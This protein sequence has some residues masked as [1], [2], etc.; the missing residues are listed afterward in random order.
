MSPDL[1]S[2]DLFT[3]AIP[4]MMTAGFVI[5]VVIMVLMAGQNVIYFIQL[6]IAY[7]VLSNR[8]VVPNTLQ[9]WR[10]L[11]VTTMPISLL[12]PAYNEESTIVENVRSML[13]LH[14]P[15]FEVIIINDGSSDN[16]LK[17]VIEAYGLEPIIRPHETEVMHKPIRGIYG[18]PHYKNLVVVDK[19]NGGKADALNAGIN[20]SRL[21]LFCAVDAD[22]I[23]EA[24]ALLRAV[25]PFADDPDRVVAVGGTIRIANG[26]SV[27]AG[28]V[29][30]VGM[31]TNLVALFQIVEYLRAFL[32]ARLAWSKLDALMLISGAFGIFKRGTAIAVGGYS[33]DTV[34]EDMEIIV[35]LHRYMRERGEDYEVKFVPDPV[36]WTE[37]PESL[38]VLGRQRR[39]WQQGSLETFFKHKAML[40]NR[41]YGIAG[42]LG[43][44]HVLL[45]DVLGPPMEVLG[46]ILIPFFWSLGAFDLDFLLAY[47]AFGFVFGVT[48]SVG[49]LIL[50]EMELKRFPSPGHLAVLTGVAVLENFGYRQINNIWRLM[51]YWQYLRGKTEWGKMTRSGFKPG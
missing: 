30:S 34:G 29:V 32:M 11:N 47:V 17:E 7:G 28:R 24:D 49:S 36:C 31:P 43:F 1:I 5:S 22:S 51:G 44:P 12:V 4:H 18:S 3:A 42:M 21:P 15:N 27:R 8:R 33:R 10:Q 40:F 45:V 41:R 35:K 37:A 48:I 46:Y 2:S 13:A 19:A 39:R 16:T 14:Y 38:A 9:A 20:L 23:L 50:E 26:C 25:Q 6:F